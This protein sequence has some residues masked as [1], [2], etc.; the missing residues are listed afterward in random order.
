MGW[1]KNQGVQNYDDHIRT[2]T[3]FQA[4]RDSK[5]SILEAD[6]EPSAK[7]AAFTLAIDAKSP[8]VLFAVQTVAV[9]S[10]PQFAVPY[11]DVHTASI[12]AIATATT[13]SDRVN[14][15]MVADVYVVCFGLGR[16]N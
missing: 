12:A 9:G 13:R 1:T 6:H 16:R 14:E 2:R 8:Q 7:H 5:S 15:R 10:P 4:S 3:T 11:D